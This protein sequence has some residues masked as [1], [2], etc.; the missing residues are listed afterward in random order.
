M[1]GPSQQRTGAT[2]IEILVVVWI[3]AMVIGVGGTLLFGGDDNKK[4]PDLT[5]S[6]QTDRRQAVQDNYMQPAG[7]VLHPDGAANPANVDGGSS[8]ADH[9][10]PDAVNTN[11]TDNTAASPPVVAVPQTSNPATQGV[12]YTG[13]RY[14][15]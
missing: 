9:T 12:P 3:A 1:R 15:H 7:K 13:A 2:I 10:S 14:G 6:S 8:T 4:N 11:A 5:S